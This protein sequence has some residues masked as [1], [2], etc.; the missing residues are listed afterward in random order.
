MKRIIAVAG[1]RLLIT[2]GTVSINGQVISE[3]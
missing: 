1:D 2:N 3:P